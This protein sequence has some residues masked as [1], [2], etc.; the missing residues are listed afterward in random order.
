M[1]VAMRLLLVQYGVEEAITVAQSGGDMLGMVSLQY[2]FLS[3]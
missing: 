1:S 2:G 3:N